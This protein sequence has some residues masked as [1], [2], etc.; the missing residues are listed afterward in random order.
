M[1]NEDK[2]RIRSGQRFFTFCLSLS[3]FI[4]VHPWLLSADAPYRLKPGEF[5][6]P[7]SAKAVGGE[8]IALDHVNRAGLIRP[9][10][11]DTQRRGEWDIARPFVMLPFGSFSY[12]GAP[13]ELRDVPIGT[14][15][16]GEFYAD[17]P[18]PDPPGKKKAKDAP[19]PKYTRAIRLE[20]DFSFNV[21]QGRA[22][23]VD[24]LDHETGTL[25]I[26]GVD[27]DGKPDPKPTAFKV[28]PA[29]RVWKGRGF[30]TLSD[31]TAKQTVQVNLTVCTLKGPGRITDV[32]LDDESRNAATA[33]QLEVHRLYQREHGLAGWVTAVDNKQGT[34]EV[35]LFGGVDP[36]LFDAFA[37]NELAAAAV[38]E[39][40]LRTWDQINDVK[41]GPV[42]AV[43]RGPAGPGNSGVR[44]RLKPSNLLEG[45]RPGR[46][47]SLFPAAWK[48]DDLPR[49]DRLYP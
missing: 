45:Y 28:S 46:V 6:P 44:V 15:L 38:A 13:A 19:P 49:E 20:D 41:R 43:E 22:W 47:V 30:G 37:V 17:D 10:R 24:A 4:C 12:H 31:V 14:H 39:D 48:V 16:H 40:S 11:D 42:L 33:R 34:V 18:P 25:T 3:V 36:K 5:P 21:R 23:R 8:V 29:T 7:D 26:T 9:D 1:K 2:R 32:W 35:L 27:R